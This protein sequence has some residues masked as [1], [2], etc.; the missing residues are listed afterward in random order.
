MKDQAPAASATSAPAA[1]L[2]RDDYRVDVNNLPVEDAVPRLIEQAAGLMASDLYFFTNENHVAVSIRHLGVLRLISILPLDLG[3]RCMAHLK[4]VAGMDV[5]ERRRPLDGRRIYRRT[6]GAQLDLRINTIPTLYGED[7][8][9][10]LLERDSRL[11]QLDQLGLLRH[12]HNRLLSMLQSPSG[13]ILVTGP[14]GSGKTTTLY[15]SLNYLNNGERK[16]N[17]IEDPI[18]YA[19]QG[20]RQSQVNPRIEV[21]FPDLLRGVL[22]QTPDV[23]MVGEIRDPV[24][25]EVAVRAANSGHLVL[26]TLHAPVAAGAV[27]SMLSLGVHPHFLASCLLGSIAQRLLRTL[28]PLCRVSYEMPDSEIFEEVQRWLEPG[29]G[30]IL[31]GPGGCEVCHGT[32]YSA[33][34]GVFEVLVLTKGLRKLVMAKQSLQMIRAKAVEEGTIEFRQAALLKVAKGETTV[35]EVFRVVPTEYLGVED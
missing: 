33:R 17:T 16:I 35:E 27:Q 13:L 31:Y 4:A 6:S 10:R 12:D 21:D 32:G 29:E 25:A 24:T 1:P 20:V 22:R 8:T 2:A 26:A 14:T 30:K 18:E 28:C 15:A 5:A 7:F 11:L 3:R 19:V 9:I 34:T 23:I